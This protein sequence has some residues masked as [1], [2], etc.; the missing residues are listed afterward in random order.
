MILSD[1]LQA[2]PLE[3]IA[4]KQTSRIKV[5]LLSVWY[6]LS[7]SRYFEK[8]LRHNDNVDLIATGPFTGNW[9]PWEGGKSLPEKYAK[10]PEIPLPFPP[11]VGRVSYD[12]VKT[13]LPE[14]WIPDLVLAIEP[15]PI[16]WS[17]KPQ[18]GYVASIGTDPHVTDY[19][20]ARSI[21]DKFFSM[22]KCYAEPTDSYLPYAY[23]VYDHYIEN[24][25]VIRGEGSYAAVLPV[26]KDSDCVLI[27]MPYERRVEWVD[28]LRK[29]GVSVTFKNEPVFDEYREIANRARIGL[30]WSSL[31][32]LNARVFETPA[33]G[34]AMVTNRVPDLP[35]FLTE[36]QD[37]LGF[38]NLAEAVDKVL[39]LKDNPAEIERLAKNGHEKIK[40]ETYDARVEQVLRECGF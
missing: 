18:D 20:H 33:F 26:K 38:S 27:G 1:M 6:P 29:H 22:Q 21:S 39:Y 5:L 11:N 34:L 10:V 7:M 4:Y 8:A 36:D 37:Y 3:S 31:N 28:K 17:S 25:K 15:Q 14:G 19:S 35:L 30:N 16:N 13:Q 23:S 24:E 9:I 2:L 40:N 32:D 12:F